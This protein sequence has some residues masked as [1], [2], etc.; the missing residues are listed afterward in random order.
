MSREHHN[1]KSM[2]LATIGLWHLLS[3]SEPQVA[4]GAASREQAAA[5]RD[6]QGMASHCR[7]EASGMAAA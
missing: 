1:G 3:A 6:R 4:V 7:V 2:L 5:Y